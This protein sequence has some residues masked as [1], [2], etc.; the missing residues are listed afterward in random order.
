MNPPHF[1]QFRA[2]NLAAHLFR[3]AAGLV[4]AI[5]IC[6]QVQAQNL[7]VSDGYSGFGRN[8]GHIYKIAPNGAVSTFASGLGGPLGMAFDNE[9]NLFVAYEGGTGGPSG[10]WKFTPHGLKSIFASGLDPY[11]LALDSAGNIFVTDSVA[12]AIYKFT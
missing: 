12:G 7:Y 6:S 11:A 4:A 5:L 10:I 9:G 1:I 8:L 2:C 3:R